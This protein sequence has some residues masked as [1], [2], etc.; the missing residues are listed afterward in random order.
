[1]TNPSNFA[2]EWCEAWNA[3]DLERVLA[4]F[5]ENVVFSSPVAA[6][7]LPETQGQVRGKE[8]LRAYWSEG[9]RRI[10][11]LHF[12]VEQVFAGIDTVVI[13]YRNQKGVSVSEVLIFDGDKVRSGYGTYPV[14]VE[15]PA[16]A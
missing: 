7:I 12:T 16:G 9:L 5:H 11:D 15:N 3:H 14:G 4:H 6:A 1:M 13:Q 2:V 10:P 8:A